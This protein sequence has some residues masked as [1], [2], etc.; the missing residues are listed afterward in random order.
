MRKTAETEL[1]AAVALEP[2]NADYHAMLAQ[3]YHG[4]GLRR[5]AQSEAARALALDPKNAAARALMAN[6]QTS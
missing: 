4:V 2:N 1:Q 6:L 5:R 3:F